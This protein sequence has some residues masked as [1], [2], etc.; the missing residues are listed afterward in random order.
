MPLLFAVAALAALFQ[1][2]DRGADPYPAARQ[3]QVLRFYNLKGKLDRG[4]LEAAVRAASMEIVYGPVEAASRPSNSVVVVSTPAEASPREVEKVLRKARVQVEELEAFL[5]EGRL[6]GG[7]PDF[8]IG[9]EKIDYMLGISGEIRWCDMVEGW[10]V[11]YCVAGRLDADE[12][13]G[14]FRKLQRGFGS[15]DATLGRGGARSVHL[16]APRRGRRCARGEAREGDREARG[17][18]RGGDR[19]PGALDHARDRRAHGRRSPA[20]LRG[21]GTLARESAATDRLHERAPGSPGR[22]GARARVRV[23][24]S[25]AAPRVARGPAGG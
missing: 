9:L 13:E 1:E 10:T 22:R 4:E 5:F 17:D 16:D 11:F 21:R 18:L 20:E 24:R 8:G 23:G 6:D 3:E 7:F 25:R 12:L 19:G 2:E 14:R 15:T